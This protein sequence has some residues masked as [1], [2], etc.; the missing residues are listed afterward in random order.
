MRFRAN[1]TSRVGGYGGV[2]VTWD[3]NV[4]FLFCMGNGINLAWSETWLRKI[5]VSILVKRYKG[6]NTFARLFSH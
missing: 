4:Y 1:S 2:M 3:L 6:V 5:P